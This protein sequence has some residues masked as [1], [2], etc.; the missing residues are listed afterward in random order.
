MAYH[1][2]SDST[3]ATAEN[4]HKREKGAYAEDKAYRFLLA[5]GLS[6]IQRNYYCKLGEIDLIMKDKDYIVFVEVRYRKNNNLGQAAMSI[7]YHKQ[8]KLIKTANHYLLYRS[9]YGNCPC[10]FDV[11]LLSLSIKHPKIEWIKDA[12]SLNYSY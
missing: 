2:R 8:T 10:R 9:Q 6:F 11:V 5:K 4:N 7:G 12:F 3:L 1:R